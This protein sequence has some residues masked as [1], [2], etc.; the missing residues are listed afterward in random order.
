MKLLV[1]TQL[2]IW[3]TLKPEKLSSVVQAQFDDANN[4]LWFSVTSLWEVAIKRGRN[5]ANF[6]IEA[7]ALRESLFDA[8]FQELPIQSNH[9][10]SLTGLPHIHKD[11]FDRLILAQAIAENMVLLTTDHVLASYPGPIKLIK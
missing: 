8:G 10:F 3:V 2:L 5:H 1:D 6:T 4:Q 7:G 11:P 9:I